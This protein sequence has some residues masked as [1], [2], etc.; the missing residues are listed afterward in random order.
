MSDPLTLLITEM[1]SDNHKYIMCTVCMHGHLE[2]GR[3]RAHGLY[4][5]ISCTSRVMGHRVISLS[6]IFFF[7]LKSALVYCLQEPTTLE[8]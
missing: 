7:L 8:L 6:A 3:T 2:E 4:L 1:N 5:G